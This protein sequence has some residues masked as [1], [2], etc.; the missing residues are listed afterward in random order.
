METQSWLVTLV[1]AR[2]GCRKTPAAFLAP[3]SSL[4]LTVMLHTRGTWRTWAPMGQAG[5]NLWAITRHWILTIHGCT[6]L[7]INWGLIPS[8]A[9]WRFTEEADL[10]WIWAQIYRTQLG[11]SYFL[12][13]INTCKEHDNNNFIHVPIESFDIFLTI[14]GL[15][16]THEQSLSSSPCTTQMLTSSALS[17]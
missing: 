16:L 2:W 1:F 13:E 17:H 15:T 4:C 11:R 14:L 10:W 8:G 9:K 3:C 5:S 7:K 12:T 6:S